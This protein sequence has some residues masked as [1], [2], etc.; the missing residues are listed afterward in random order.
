MAPQQELERVAGPFS[1]KDK[2]RS[3][4]SQGP[5]GV[6]SGDRGKLVSAPKSQPTRGGRPWPRAKEPWWLERQAQRLLHSSQCRG[7]EGGREDRGQ[8]TG[9]QRSSSR[10][11]RPCTV[12]VRGSRRASPC[13]WS[14]GTD[15]SP[16]PVLGELIS[17]EV[18]GCQLNG[19]LGGDKGQV[20]GGSCGTR[21][22]GEA[23]SQ[24]LLP[25]W[26]SPAPVNPWP[27]PP[28]LSPTLVPGGTG[29]RQG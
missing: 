17:E 1:S 13:P 12:K 10:K 26:Q 19:L 25:S 16:S 23:L 5:Q 6:T 2:W 18:V 3:W 11:E 14:G 24:H 21:S 15:P 4:G 9:Q 27:P 22:V 8:R 7:G 29:T 20:H 28:A